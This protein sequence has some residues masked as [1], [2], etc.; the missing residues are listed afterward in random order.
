[1]SAIILKL[2]DI[3][4]LR[5]GP[6]DMPAQMPLGWI[7]AVL[8]L[9]AYVAEGLVADRILE[10]AETAPRSLLAITLQITI[11]GALLQF[12]GFRSRLAQTVSALAG[13]GLLFGFLSVVVLLQA[14]PGRNQPMLAMIWILTFLWSLAVD[15]HIY[16]LALS[17]KISQGVLVAIIIY[18]VNYFVA[19]WVFAA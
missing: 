8:L 12:R 17:T 18:S 10:G 1:M 9:L 5:G 6:Q 14:T 16:R 2:L 13:T 7:T 11:V 4:R 15:A 19:Q 3:M